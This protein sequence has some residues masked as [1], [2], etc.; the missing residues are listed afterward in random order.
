MLLPVLSLLTDMTCGAEAHVQVSAGDPL[1]PG[2]ALRPDT[3]G[4]V[5]VRAVPDSMLGSGGDHL[6]TSPV[7][8]TSEGQCTAVHELRTICCKGGVLT[9][10][11][12]AENI[13]APL[14]ICRQRGVWRPHRPGLFESFGLRA[15]QGDGEVGNGRIT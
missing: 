3:K 9:C 7:S 8:V 11:E 4:C 14:R 1:K 12:D 2:T 6:S 5:R 10:I 15:Q 13:D